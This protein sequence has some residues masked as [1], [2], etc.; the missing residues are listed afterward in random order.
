MKMNRIRLTLSALVLGLGLAASGAPIAH[1]LEARIEAC[2]QIMPH[3]ESVY[4]F[5]ADDT[6][7]VVVD[8]VLVGSEHITAAQRFYLAAIVN[9]L[10]SIPIDELPDFKEYRTLT[11]AMCLTEIGT[12]YLYLPDDGPGMLD[13]PNR[14]AEL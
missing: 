8:T 12:G 1:T 9:V 4:V 10:W 7:R 6:P 2:A 5:R 11:Y 3:F 14:R 13:K